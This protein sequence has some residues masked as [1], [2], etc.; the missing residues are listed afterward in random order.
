MLMQTTIAIVCG[1]ESKAEVTMHEEILRCHSKTLDQLFKKAMPVRE[2]YAE[3]KS[4]CDQLAAFVFPEITI[5]EFED[6]GA[7]EMV[8]TLI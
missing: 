7:E 8:R 4:I 3:S 6:T 5:K 1:Q 2:Q